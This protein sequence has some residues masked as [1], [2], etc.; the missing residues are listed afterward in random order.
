MRQRCWPA[1]LRTGAAIACLALSAHARAVIYTS[2]FDPVGFGG[3]ATFNIANNCVATNG[4][5]ATNFN[6]FDGVITHPSCGSA[7]LISSQVN[8]SPGPITDL[9]N[10]TGGSPFDVFGVF[11]QLGLITGIDT[12]QIG[13]SVASPVAT[14]PTGPLWLD[15]TSGHLPGL[16]P[17]PPL[18]VSLFAG[19]CSPFCVPNEIP[20]GVAREVT[21]RAPEPGTIALLMGSLCAL[22]FVT[23]RRPTRFS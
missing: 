18:A 7:V 14:F 8:N 12:N 23:R 4:W 15:F 20:V 17:P 10:Y 21:F 9:V 3:T 1:L 22:G 6:Y 16:G 13:P 19:T 11:V 5:H 2:D